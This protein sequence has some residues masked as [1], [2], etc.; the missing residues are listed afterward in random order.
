MW[1]LRDEVVQK[2][3]PVKKNGK[4]PIFLCPFKN[5][6]KIGKMHGNFKLSFHGKTQILV[7]NIVTK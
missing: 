5:I 7:V 6:A 4:V 1:L 2:S 3:E